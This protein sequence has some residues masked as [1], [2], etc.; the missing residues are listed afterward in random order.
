MAPFPEQ[1]DVSMAP[2]WRM[3]QLIGLYSQKE[4]DHFFVS[5]HQLPKTNFTNNNDFGA[6]L[7]SLYATFKEFKMHEQI[8][9]YIIGFLQQRGW[10]VCSVHSDNKFS[11]MLGL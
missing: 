7:Q 9:E 8:E 11:E 10:T 5:S 6:L 2:Q 3:K 1:V 4:T